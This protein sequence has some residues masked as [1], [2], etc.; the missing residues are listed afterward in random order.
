MASTAAPTSVP[1]IGEARWRCGAGERLGRAGAAFNGAHGW[2]VGRVVPAAAALEGEG[3]VADEEEDNTRKLTDGSNR[4]EKDRKEG[5]DV[6]GGASTRAG[7]W[8]VH[9]RSSNDCSTLTRKSGGP[10]ARKSLGF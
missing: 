6:W 5:I 7:M 10:L 2:R 1:A 3:Q 9:A 4:M 8:R